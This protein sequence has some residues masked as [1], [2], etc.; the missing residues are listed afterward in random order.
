MYTQ[1]FINSKDHPNGNDTGANTIDR[2]PKLKEK[3]IQSLDSVNKESSLRHQN[4]EALD[5]KTK[6]HVA[7]MYM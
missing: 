3:F 1:K 2:K 5:T 4:N 6:I 7:R